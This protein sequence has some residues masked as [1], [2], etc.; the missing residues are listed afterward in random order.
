[1]IT[2][3][4]GNTKI[5]KIPNVSLPPIATCAD[6]LPCFSKCYA[7]KSYRMFPSVKKAWDNNLAVYQNKPE[8]YFAEL[9]SFLTKI[10][11]EYFRFHVSGD[12]PDQRYFDMIVKLAAKHTGTKFLAYTKK[13]NLDFSCRPINVN[14]I[15]SVWTGFGDIEL[16]ASKNLPI[17][18]YQDGTET[19]IPETAKI[20]NSTCDI[21][22]LC[23]HIKENQ[24]IVFIHH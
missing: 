15:A 24:S 21:C 17:A 12:I 20:C 1:M 14:V 3:S 18:W 16:I 9:D 6:A 10:E 11:T 5:G 2:I 22:K 23:W 19:R 13:Y 7:I 8:A 4:R